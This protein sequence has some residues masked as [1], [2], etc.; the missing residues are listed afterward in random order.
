MQSIALGD[1]G[2]SHRCATA[3]CEQATGL[4]NSNCV[5]ASWVVYTRDYEGKGAALAYCYLIVL[6]SVPLK[7]QCGRWSGDMIIIGWLVT[8]RQRL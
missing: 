2:A 7:L 4:L 6:A 5:S 8:F 3:D 1:T